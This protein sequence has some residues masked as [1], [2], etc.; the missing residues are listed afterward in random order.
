MGRLPRTRPGESPP[1]RGAPRS[2][3]RGKNSRRKAPRE[4]RLPR[5][6][7]IVV[8]RP[9]ALVIVASQDAPEVVA[10]AGRPGSRLRRKTASASQTF[11]EELPPRK[12]GGL[13]PRG[14]RRSCPP[15][16]PPGDCPPRKRPGAACRGTPEELARQDL[17]Q[18][19]RRGLGPGER[20][21]GHPEG[22][23]AQD[24]RRSCLPRTCRRS[25]RPGLRRSCLPRIAGGL[26]RPASPGAA[27]PRLSGGA[28]CRGETPGGNGSEAPRGMPAEDTPGGA[29]LPKPSRR[30]CL[31]RNPGGAAAEETPR[32]LPGVEGRWRATG[33]PNP[34]EG[35]LVRCFTCCPFVARFGNGGGPNP[36]T[37]TSRA[38]EKRNQSPTRKG[39]NPPSPGPPN[40]LSR[41]FSSPPSGHISEYHSPEKGFNTMQKQLWGGKNYLP[42]NLGETLTFG[43]LSLKVIKPP[44]PNCSAPPLKNTPGPGKPH[45][46]TAQVAEPLPAQ[47]RAPR[48]LPQSRETLKRTPLSTPDPPTSHPALTKPSGT[49]TVTGGWRP[50]GRKPLQTPKHYGHPGSSENPPKYQYLIDTKLAQ[51]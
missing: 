45:P 40:D 3:L 51:N 4:S 26:P 11:P 39:Q 24:C 5:A 35:V 43:G 1:R 15:R 10:C 27:F 49:F 46:Y 25:A 47:A 17:P 8:A 44:Y 19:C 36:K 16:K 33:A 48:P 22:L 31:P 13:P 32:G 20:P 30:G 7:R 28:A 37:P 41:G 14:T 9:N 42:L 12:P 34:T 38:G 21:R 23:P 6:R 29:R 18:G 2:R 50:Q